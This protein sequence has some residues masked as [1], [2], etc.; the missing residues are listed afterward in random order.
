MGA[1]GVHSGG[2]GAELG[3]KGGKLDIFKKM[4]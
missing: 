3:E 4:S 2:L 1:G